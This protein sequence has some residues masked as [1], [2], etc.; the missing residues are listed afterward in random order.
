MV[1]RIYGTELV[2]LTMLTMSAEKH[3]PSSSS[4]LLR[5][6]TSVN[7]RRYGTVENRYAAAGVC[8]T[9]C[10]LSLIVMFITSYIDP[11]TN[12]QEDIYCG[13]SGS[14]VEGFAAFH[15]FFNISCQVGGF[16][17]SA[18]AF[19]VARKLTKQA[20]AK[21]LNAIRPILLISFIS[22]I[23][24]SSSNIVRVLKS[25]DLSLGVRRAFVC[26]SEP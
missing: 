22:C 5:I 21:E 6:R 15:Q 18:F 8:A 24:I 19:L 12:V 16:F 2:S 11:R 3:F 17:G 25:I 7:F 26:Y 23:V 4:P 10:L 14:T 9:V 13:I 1:F 20:S